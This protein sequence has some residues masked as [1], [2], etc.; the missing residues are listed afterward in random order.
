MANYRQTVLRAFQEV[1][2]QLSALQTLNAETRQQS[3]AEQEAEQRLSLIS[4][5][6]EGGISNQQSV[7][8]SHLQVY[9]DQLALVDL[10]RRR[11]QASVNLIKA[12]GG[13]WSD[14]QL[15]QIR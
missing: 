7:L 14:A 15:A 8:L 3:A 6:Y 5:R 9:S 11:L 13:G 2:D 1:E 10:D 4:V 12:T